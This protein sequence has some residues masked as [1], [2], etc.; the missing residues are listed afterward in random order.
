MGGN[1]VPT[2]WEGSS[3]GGSPMLPPESYQNP[4]WYDQQISAPAWSG[5]TAVGSGY[6]SPVTIDPSVPEAIGPNYGAAAPT[7]DHSYDDLG[8]RTADPYPQGPG[9]GTITDPNAAGF[10]WGKLANSILGLGSGVA[11]EINRK[12]Q[13]TDE[14]IAAMADPWGKSGGRALAD[15]Q[16]QALLKNPGQVQDQDPAFKARIQA[17]QRASGAAGQDSGAMSVAGA[18]ASTSWYDQ[19]IAQLAAISGATVNPGTSAQLASGQGQQNYNQLMQNMGQGAFGVK[20]AV[21]G[22]TSSGVSGGNSDFIKQL[23]QALPS[24]VQMARGAIA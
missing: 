8:E 9:T 19:H 14:Q 15:T 22:A 16:L 2:G 13:F 1:N 6:Q 7:V 17:A 12:N 20:Q 5:G 21:G 4:S 24:L 18:G 11:G 10:D 3:P 23:Q